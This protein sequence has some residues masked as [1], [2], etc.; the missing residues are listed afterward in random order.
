LVNRA[1]ILVWK[2]NASAVADVTAGDTL[3]MMTKHMDGDTFMMMK[4]FTEQD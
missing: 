4:L 2:N 1:N 3:L